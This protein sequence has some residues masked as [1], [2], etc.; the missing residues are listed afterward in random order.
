MIHLLKRFPT[1]ITPQ[2]ITR[3]TIEEILFPTVSMS[4]IGK[5]REIHTKLAWGNVNNKLLL[6]SHKDLAWQAA[7]ECLPTRAFLK[8]RECTRSA[9]CPRKRCGED[10]KVKHIF[11]ECSFAK[12]YWGLLGQWLKDLSKKE[13]TYETIMYGFL[14]INCG[15]RGNMLVDNSK[16]CKRC[17]VESEKHL[18]I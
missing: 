1:K 3:A 13:L 6:N 11:W 4:L 9:Q 8:K 18:C 7:Q 2:E 5:L 15:L 16:L 14:K 12:K 10:E 17:F